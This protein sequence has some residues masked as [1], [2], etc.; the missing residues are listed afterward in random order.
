MQNAIGIIETR[1]FATAIQA[2]DAA[3]K[4]AS[5]QLG[6]WIKV[7]GGK[8]NIIII[9]EVAAVKA[10]LE[11]GIASAQEI[12][13]V[14][15]HVVIPRPSEKLT[16][17]PLGIPGKASATPAGTGLTS[18]GILETRGLAPLVYGADAA[19]KAAHVELLEWRQVGSG[20]VS[21]VVQGDV[22][23]VQSAINAGRASAES[24]GEVISEAV[25]PRPAESVELALSGRPKPARRKT[26]K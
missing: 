13:E 21:F 6:D 3:I 11:A 2:A 7:G 18:L 9:G 12:G 26:S 25:I 20:F 8:V 22:A 14:Q 19:V 1:G 10:A 17:F 16:V 4:A 24:I 15:S 23:S 5:V